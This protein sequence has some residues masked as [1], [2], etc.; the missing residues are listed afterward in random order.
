[1][2]LGVHTKNSKLLDWLVYF[3]SQSQREVYYS[4]D[5]QLATKSQ[6]ICARREKRHMISSLVMGTA[7]RDE[8]LADLTSGTAV[9]Q[10]CTSVTVSN[11]L[12]THTWPMVL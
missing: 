3:R 2:L 9:R 12:A 7:T 6:H 4:N 1:M 5:S 10:H 11:V 8:S